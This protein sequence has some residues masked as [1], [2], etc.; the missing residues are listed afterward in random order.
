MKIDEKFN[1][2]ESIALIPLQKIHKCAFDL[3]YG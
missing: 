2:M 1:A 3:G